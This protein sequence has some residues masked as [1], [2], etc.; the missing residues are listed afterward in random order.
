MHF[1]SWTPGF[2][3]ADVSKLAINRIEW[4]KAAQR[5]KRKKKRER[6]DGWKIK[7]KKDECRNSSKK[8]RG[9]EKRK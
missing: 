7:N 4:T 3:Y 1:K 2:T 6:G 5:E 8:G 9:R